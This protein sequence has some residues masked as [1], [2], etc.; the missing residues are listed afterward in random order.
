MENTNTK[1]TS[2]PKVEKNVAPTFKRKGELTATEIAALEKATVTLTKSTNKTS[3][4][5]TYS[6]VMELA[7][8]S[9][10]DSGNVKIVN[11]TFD[12]SK[13]IFNETKFELFKELYKKPNH[14]QFVLKAPIRL[15]KGTTASEG[16]YYR[17]E[18]F[19]AATKQSFMF[20]GFLS[21][22]IVELLARRKP[23]NTFIE[24]PNTTSIDDLELEDLGSNSIGDESGFVL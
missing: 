17:Y 4:L 14:D 3:G 5:V 13:R 18:I 10:D 7:T 1:G 15:I 9:K 23:V 24:N 22:D 11:V 8:Q 12:N 21:S 16:K 19:L 6:L 20:S 2:T